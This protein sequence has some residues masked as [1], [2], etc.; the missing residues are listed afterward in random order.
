MQTK[1]LMEKLN[2][3]KELE[4]LIDRYLTRLF[5]I[6]RSITG[7]GNRK[8]LHILQEI[9]PIQIKEYRQRENRANYQSATV[10]LDTITPTLPK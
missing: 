5:P 1:I 2:A 10:N 3:S 8:S 4:I 9:A 6:T 7:E